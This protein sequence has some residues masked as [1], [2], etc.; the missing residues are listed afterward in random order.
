MKNWF[1]K[2]IALLALCLCLNGCIA[3]AAATAYGVSRHRT[4]K[5]YNEYVASMDK[6]N[7]DRKSQ[8]LEPLPVNT[9][10]E[11]KKNR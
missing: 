10:E 3:A 2:V 11:W 4:H 5:S 7:Q 9:F 6:T 8:G 1:G